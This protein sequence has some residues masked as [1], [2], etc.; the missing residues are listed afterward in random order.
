[1]P[2]KAEKRKQQRKTDDKHKISRFKSNYITNYIKKQWGLT[3]PLGGRD[4]QTARKI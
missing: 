2:K 4:C 3:T 1:M